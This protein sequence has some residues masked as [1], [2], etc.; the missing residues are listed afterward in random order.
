MQLRKSLPDSSSDRPARSKLRAPRRDRHIDTSARKTQPKF[1][2]VLV[3]AARVLVAAPINCSNGA[4]NCFSVVK[5][6]H[7]FQHQHGP[8]HHQHLHV[9]LLLLLLLLLP[10]L[11]SAVCCC[12]LLLLLLPLAAAAAAWCRCCCSSDCCNNHVSD[13]LHRVQKVK[14]ARSQSILGYIL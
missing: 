11:L 14:S 9:L 1:S 12:R 7:R 4:L 2:S 8:H 10:P 13:T 6:C 5:S 3:Q